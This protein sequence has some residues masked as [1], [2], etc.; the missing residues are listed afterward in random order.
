MGENIGVFLD[1][2]FL[3]EPTQPAGKVKLCG[4]TYDLFKADIMENFLALMAMTEKAAAMPDAVTGAA[5][6]VEA[7]KAIG[8]TMENLRQELRNMIRVLVPGIPEKVL[9]EKLPKLSQLQGAFTMLVSQANKQIP[10]HV[11]KNCERT[12]DQPA[13]TKTDS[14][15]ICS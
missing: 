12:P 8:E 14:A 2:D 4:E 15:K 5:D 13:T 6:S 10:E 7:V 1:L 9:R 11:K 3:L